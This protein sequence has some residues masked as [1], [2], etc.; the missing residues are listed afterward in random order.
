MEGAIMAA[1]AGYLILM[2]LMLDT[3]NLRSLIIFK[4][5]PGCLGLALAF[6]TLQEFGFIIKL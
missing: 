6:L 2:G 5:I 3:K 4:L 1:V